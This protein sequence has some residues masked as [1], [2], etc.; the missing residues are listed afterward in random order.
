MRGGVTEISATGIGRAADTGRRAVMHPAVLFAA[1]NTSLALTQAERLGIALNVVLVT[2]MIVVRCWELRRAR[3][4][5]IPF[6]LLAAVNVA[7]AV[8]VEVNVAMRS[9][10]GEVGTGLSA[11]VIAAHVSAFAFVSWSAGH[12]MAH[13]QE[14]RG[15]SVRRVR[16]N[17]QAYYGAADLAAV[18][19]SGA[20]NPFATPFVVIG[21]G[22]SLGNGRG[23]GWARGRFGAFVHREVTAARLYGVGFTVG[24]LTSLSMPGFATAQACWAMAYFL[25]PRA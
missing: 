22:R 2:T 20:V 7:T 19:A 16:E 12:L 24:A 8:S 3:P 18:S 4:L 14:V 17:P 15:G 1:G 23:G 10:A 25:F 6:V 9:A 5:G 11:D 21:L 13:R